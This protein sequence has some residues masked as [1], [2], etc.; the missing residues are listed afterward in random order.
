M[1]KVSTGFS[2]REREATPALA[3]PAATSFTYSEREMRP[4][5]IARGSAT[6]RRSMSHQQPLERAVARQNPH[7]ETVDLLRHLSSP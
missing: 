7:Q 6:R 5:T 4:L 1:Y 2:K 3:A